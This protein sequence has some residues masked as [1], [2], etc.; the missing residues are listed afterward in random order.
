MKILH[1]IA[2][3]VKNYPIYHTCCNYNRLHTELED[4]LRI[5]M[6][7][8][9]NLYPGPSKPVCDLENVAGTRLV[10]SGNLRR[11]NSID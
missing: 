3:N 5:D 6:R 8:C 1:E 11:Q 2:K 9:K 10:S 4:W 7:P